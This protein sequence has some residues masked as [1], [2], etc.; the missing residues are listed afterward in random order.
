MGRSGWT[1]D[2]GESEER[3]ESEN[4]R[5]WVMVAGEKGGGGLG[6]DRKSEKKLGR[7]EVSSEKEKYQPSADGRIRAGTTSE[8]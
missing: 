5:G 6:L 7:G 8:G 2:E 4:G 1:S 3:E